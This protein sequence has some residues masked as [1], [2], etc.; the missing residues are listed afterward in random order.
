LFDFYLILI[1]NA[2]LVLAVLA[3]LVLAGR[4]A[5]TILATLAT[6][7]CIVAVLVAIAHGHTVVGHIDFYI[8][9]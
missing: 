1:K 3:I 7:R 2:N 8:H 4:T 9:T 5:T 6:H